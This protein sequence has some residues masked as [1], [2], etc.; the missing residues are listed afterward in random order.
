MNSLKRSTR[1]FVCAF[2]VFFIVL[3]GIAL[4]AGKDFSE[5]TVVLDREKG[6]AEFF[7]VKLVFDGTFFEKVEKLVRFNDNIFGKGFSGMLKKTSDF[8][9]CY[10]GDVL[11]MAYSAAEMAVGSG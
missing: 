1:D 11:K 10:A 5:G 6:F 7:G 3:M 9:F 4:V 2:L 8:A